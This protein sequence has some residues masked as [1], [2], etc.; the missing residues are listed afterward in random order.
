VDHEGHDRNAKPPDDQARLE[1]HGP[2]LSS[3][4]SPT[5]AFQGNAAPTS[6]SMP[7]ASEIILHVEPFVV[8]VGKRGS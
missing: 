6:A 7:S 2:T 4:G 1:T 5:G 3:R 8:W